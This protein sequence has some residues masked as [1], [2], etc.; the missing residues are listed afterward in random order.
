MDRGRRARQ[1]IKP[2][3]EGSVAQVGAISANGDQEIGDIIARAM[4]TVGKDGV[5]TIEESKTMHTGLETVE[6]MQFDRG[7]LSPYFVTDAGAHGSGSRGSLH[8]DLREED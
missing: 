8:P 5:I 6:G 2:V 3:D 1:N 7:Y 4:K